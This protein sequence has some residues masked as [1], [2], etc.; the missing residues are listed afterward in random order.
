MRLLSVFFSM[1]LA[2]A[3]SAQTASLVPPQPA[4]ASQPAQAAA[5]QPLKLGDWTVSG[6]VRLRGYG[7][8]WFKPTSGEN[9]YQYSGNI[10]R[11]S[12]AAAPRG[13]ELNAEFA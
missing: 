13:T 11:I 5:P 2:A 10:L 8:N 9:G 1:F 12:L 7:W 4:A 3:V 6:S